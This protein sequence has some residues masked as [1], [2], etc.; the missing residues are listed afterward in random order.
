MSIVGQSV[1]YVVT[2]SVA[3]PGSAVNAVPTGVV[4]FTDSVQGVMGNASLL[5]TDTQAIAASLPFQLNAGSHAIQA[6]YF[7]DSNY[8]AASTA[9]LLVNISQGLF[10]FLE[11]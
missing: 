9:T 8:L 11:K 7:G 3:A 2:V 6:S 1:S 5:V 10:F 4:Q